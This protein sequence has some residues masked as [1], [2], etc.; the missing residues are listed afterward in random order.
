MS[1]LNQ[2]FRLNGIVD[3]SRGVFE[4]L[5]Q[6]AMA[7]G[8]WITYDANAGRWSVLINQAGTSSK[9]FDDSNIIGPVNLSSTS[10][11]DYYNRVRVTYARSDLDDQIDFVEARTPSQQLRPGE[12]DNTLEMTLDLVTDPVQALNIGARELKQSRVNQIVT[13]STDYSSMGLQAGDIIDITN[14]AMAFESKLFR[15]VQM[16]ENDLDTGEIEIEITALEYSDAVYNNDLIRLDRTVDN[17]IVTIGGIAQPAAPGVAIT[18]TGSRPHLEL[19]AVVPAGLVA[20]M[21]FWIS[22]NG[23]DF[24]LQ[25]TERPP[26][27]GVYSTGAAVDLDVQNIN[28]GTIAVRVRAINSQTSSVF[29]NTTTVTYQP[30]Q[31]TD[32]VNPNTR[33]EDGLGGLATVLAITELLK[34]VDGLFAQD[35]SDPATDTLFSGIETLLLDDPE[36]T[37]NISGLTT[38]SIGNTDLLACVSPTISFIA[39]TDIELTADPLNNTVTFDV[40]GGGSGNGNGFTGY[41]S[42]SYRNFPGGLVNDTPVRINTADSTELV[43]VF[44][45]AQVFPGQLHDLSD[46]IRTDLDMTEAEFDDNNIELFYP[47]GFTRVFGG[48][49]DTGN[50]GIAPFPL[51]TQ[52]S[53]DPTQVDGQGNRLQQDPLNNT[54]LHIPTQHDPDRPALGRLE[55][56]ASMVTGTTEKYGNITYPVLDLSYRPAATSSHA[57][58]LAQ[59]GFGS[60]PAKLNNTAFSMSLGPPLDLGF[61]YFV[62]TVDVFGEFTQQEID[63][64]DYDFSANFVCDGQILSS[65]SRFAAAGAGAALINATY[66]RSPDYTFSGVG[67]DSGNIVFSGTITSSAFTNANIRIIGYE[68]LGLPGEHPAQFRR[69]YWNED[70]SPPDDYVGLNELT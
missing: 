7:S 5:E 18:Q 54:N 28:A 52:V 58:Q 24:Y 19:S 20:G 64:A 69:E 29:S 40:T 36:F 45:N 1:I 57:R 25:G 65:I 50:V 42:I 55:S 39:G 35:R 43:R 60:A 17:Q 68:D 4:N 23:S 30:V 53:W 41:N 2:Q 49:L 32:A 67:P 15:I 10:L 12:A 22:Y 46:K 3:T 62:I 21:E 33:I 51:R 34:G 14:S 70:N 6:F 44:R 13:F 59:G 11:T 63:E 66:I 9:S 47:T 26:A 48:A 38:I 56:V 8:C 16:R 37:G 61:A 31:T 27:G